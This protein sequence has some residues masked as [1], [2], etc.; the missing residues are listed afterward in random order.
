MH[1]DLWIL[2]TFEEPPGTHIIEFHI[3]KITVV[4]RKPA[5]NH[6]FQGTTNFFLENV[7]NEMKIFYMGTWGIVMQYPVIQS[8]YL[9]PKFQ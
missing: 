1:N 8:N 3:I 5:N 7:I 4:Q 2:Q 9:I 6:S